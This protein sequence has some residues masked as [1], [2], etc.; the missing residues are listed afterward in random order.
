MKLTHF[1]PE[2]L[3]VEDAEAEFYVEVDDQL[4]TQVELDL[5]CE[6]IDQPGQKTLTRTVGCVPAEIPGLGT[7]GAYAC[8]LVWKVDLQRDNDLRDQLVTVKIKAV[9]RP[10]TTAAPAIRTVSPAAI[11]VVGID[12]TTHPALTRIMHHEFATR[13]GLTFDPAP[14]RRYLNSLTMQQ[15]QLLI[16]SVPGNPDGRLVIFVT[17]YRQATRRMYADW[18][19]TTQGVLANATFSVFYCRNDTKMKTA[20]PSTSP[21]T[22]I[23]HTECFCVNLRN[24]PTQAW[25][26]PPPGARSAPGIYGGRRPNEWLRKDTK[27]PV[28]FMI[29]ALQP[30]P[31][32]SNRGIWHA[33]YEA[34]TGHN[35]MPG[36]SVHGMINTK[37][38]W[39]LF[40]NFN[41]PERVRDQMDRIYRKVERGKK[42]K[43][44]VIAELKSIGYAEPGSRKFASAYDKFFKYD[45]NFAYLWFCHEIVGIKYYSDTD[46]WETKGTAN[47]YMVAGRDDRIDLFP[48]SET[49]QKPA[50]N[51][52]DE[53][54]LAYHEFDHHDR[55]IAMGPNLF[56]ENIL[57]FKTAS[58][59]SKDMATPLTAA[60]LTNWTWAD[61]YFYQE[62][63]LQAETLTRADVEES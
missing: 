44:A 55:M 1:Q 41:W 39:M 51:S 22:L 25:L 7:T 54:H 60:Q 15:R 17:L 14:L 26:R 30:S 28:R 33:I 13:D 27:A 34:K 3:K 48:L 62:N 6:R 12:I 5:E 24:G 4:P 31:T 36:N 49:G 10:G 43:A 61:V 35:I 46:F 57:G 21:I 50:Y 20:H 29:A 23:C 53:G 18:T 38:C 16:R 19:E 11:A 42:G 8:R 47:D 45:R 2:Q 9:R 52:A 40:R 63:N 32:V 56:Q 59:F 37:G 58:D